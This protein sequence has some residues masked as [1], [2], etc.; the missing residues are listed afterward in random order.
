MYEVVITRTGTFRPESSSSPGINSRRPDHLMNDTKTST[1]S[2]EGISC[3]SSWTSWGSL[4]D[5]VNKLLSA[6]GVSGRGTPG[7]K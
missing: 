7:R 5:P 3:K 4:G 2:A 1:P 6:S